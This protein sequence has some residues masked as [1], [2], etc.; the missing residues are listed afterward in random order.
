M[1]PAICAG[2]CQREP[3]MRPMYRPTAENAPVVTP[4][5]I[6]EVHT[7]TRMN[8]KLTPT[9]KA[10]MLHATASGSMCRQS[11]SAF[12]LAFSSS[13]SKASRTMLPPMKASSAKMIQWSTAVTYLLNV[14]AAK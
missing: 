7:F 8:A 13:S 14:D 11:N 2:F 10:S 3:K 5:M 9:A 12:S 4:M 6:T 1:P